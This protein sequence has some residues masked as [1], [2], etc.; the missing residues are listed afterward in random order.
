MFLMKLHDSY[1]T[2]NLIHHPSLMLTTRFKVDSASK[3]RQSSEALPSVTLSTQVEH[4]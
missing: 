4:R 3:F 1:F 2:L